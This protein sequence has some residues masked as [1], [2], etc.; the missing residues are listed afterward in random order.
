MAKKPLYNSNT[1]ATEATMDIARLRTSI[2][3]IKHLD[4][5]DVRDPKM[6]CAVGK[7]LM[8][9][10][11][12]LCEIMLHFVCRKKTEPNGLTEWPRIKD[13]LTKD[14]C[15]DV[16]AEVRVAAYDMKGIKNECDKTFVEPDELKAFIYAVWVF[17]MWAK[18]ELQDSKW[19]APALFL[20]DIIESWY[21]RFESEH[22][23]FSN[24][25]RWHTIYY[26]EGGEEKYTDDELDEINRRRKGN[27]RESMAPLYIYYILKNHHSSKDNR[28]HIQEIKDYLWDDY[29]ID[30]GRGAIGRALI[31]L[32]A[33]GDTNI[34]KGPEK[35]SGYWYSEK[36]ENAEE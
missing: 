18:Q 14:N 7:S 13:L 26:G 34:W 8:N 33:A 27:K 5:F 11:Y 32:E 17:V 22:K 12:D 16:P 1:E 20:V 24:D 23:K 4:G 30:L 21:G 10:V 35:G 36:D 19:I 2:E 6:V 25:Y 29:E 9:H 28:F 3:T 31:T 15:V